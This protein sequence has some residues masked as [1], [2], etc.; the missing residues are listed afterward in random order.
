MAYADVIP[1]LIARLRSIPGVTVGWG[2]PQSIHTTPYVFGL[3]AG[4][5]SGRVGQVQRDRYQVTIYGVVLFQDNEQAEYEL[6]PLVTALPGAFDPRQIDHD[7]HPYATLGGTVNV[8]QVTALRS[9]EVDGFVT[10]GEIQY[11]A[12]IVDLEITEKA[13]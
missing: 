13:L 12:V 7:G 6:A 8:A 11:R 2:L 4:G 1:G 5:V 3:Y 9:G 10:I